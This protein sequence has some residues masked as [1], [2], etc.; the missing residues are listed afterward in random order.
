[1]AIGR[2][3]YPDKVDYRQEGQDDRYKKLLLKT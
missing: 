2:I 1:M 3:T